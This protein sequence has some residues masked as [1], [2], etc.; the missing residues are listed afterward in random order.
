MKL[1]KQTTCTRTSSSFCGH[2]GIVDEQALMHK[3]AKYDSLINNIQNKRM[4]NGPPH[5]YHSWHRGVIHEQSTNKLANLK[6]P[7]ANIKTLMKKYTKTPLN[8]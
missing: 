3:H 6:I 8:I 2:K 1:L 5:H 7:K 4:E